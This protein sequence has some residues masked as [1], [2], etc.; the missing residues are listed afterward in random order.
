MP[1][2]KPDSVLDDLRISW[3]TDTGTVNTD[4]QPDRSNTE[5]ITL[6][7][8]A[9]LDQLRDDTCKLNCNKRFPDTCPSL[10]FTQEVSVSFG[11][12]AVGAVDLDSFLGS[13][14]CADGPTAGQ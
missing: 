2:D 11:A 1:L 9:T 5:T 12:T 14:P 8:G 6:D 3:G 4:G 7:C 10:P 13:A